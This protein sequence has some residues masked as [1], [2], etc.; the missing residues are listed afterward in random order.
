M[1]SMAYG[2][3]ARTEWRQA[4][5]II[6]LIDAGQV[7]THRLCNWEL[8][9]WLGSVAW[10]PVTVPIAPIRPVP[11]ILGHRLIGVT[12]PPDDLLDF[13]KARRLLG[14]LHLDDIEPGRAVQA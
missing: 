3:Y 4:V 12:H 13:V 11:P 2:D 14:C 8:A 1:N 10:L 5:D 6:E 7:A 9:H